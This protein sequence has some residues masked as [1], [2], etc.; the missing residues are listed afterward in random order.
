MTRG[1]VG[2]PK[3]NILCPDAWLAI[4]GDLTNG[5]GDELGTSRAAVNPKFCAAHSS[6]ALAANA[7]GPWRTDP[8]T[9][10]VAGLTG[11]ISFQF[12][13]A[14]SAGVKRHGAASGC[15]RPYT[16]H[17][18]GDRIQ[19]HGVPAAKGCDVR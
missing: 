9:L 10:S 7:F 16:D 18:I 1:D 17:G 2:H 6:S 5:A 12:E 11:F 19:V 3:E 14:C 13:H 8:R 15:P 4:E